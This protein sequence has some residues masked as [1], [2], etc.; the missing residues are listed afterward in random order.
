[1]QAGRVVWDIAVTGWDVLYDEEFVPNEGY[2]RIIRKASKVATGEEPI[3]NAFTAN[4]PGKVV[5]T[6]DNLTSRRKKAVVYR[7]IIKQTASHD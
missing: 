4:E 2:T 3:R 1:M 7:H 5:L 6:V